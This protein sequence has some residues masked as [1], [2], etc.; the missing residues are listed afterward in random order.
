MSL[1][2]RAGRLLDVGGGTGA[3]AKFLKREGYARQTGVMDAVVPSDDPEI[4]FHSR[5][6]LNDASAIDNFFQYNQPTPKQRGQ[7]VIYV[8]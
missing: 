8:N 1:V 2:P 4:D 3:T 7:S 6:D 5:T